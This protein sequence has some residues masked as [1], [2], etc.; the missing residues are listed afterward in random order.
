MTGEKI[1][2]SILALVLV[3]LVV[4]K[5]APNLLASNQTIDTTG[6]DETVGQ[7]VI[8]GAGVAAPT[9]LSYAANWLFSPPVANFLPTQSIQPGSGTVNVSSSSCGCGN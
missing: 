9:Y 6:A 7:S 2:L 1:F 4:H 3:A 8:N 5:L